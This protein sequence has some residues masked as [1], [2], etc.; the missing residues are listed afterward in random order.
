MS[1]TASSNV[2]HAEPSASQSLSGLPWLFSP[3]VDICTF[4]GSALAAFALLAVGWYRGWLTSDSPEWS[5]VIGVLLIDVAHVYST[6]FRVYFDREE[7]RHRP[8]LYGLTPLLAFLI[9]WALHSESIELFWRTLAY[10]AVFHFIRQQYG[11]VALYR[12]RGSEHDRW[13]WWID[14]TAIYL[15]TIYPLVH[16]HGEL[17]RQ[18]WWLRQGDFAAIP[19][20]VSDLLMPIYWAAMAV[21]AGRSLYRGMVHGRWNPG[22]DMVVATTALCWYVGIITF[23]SD[24]AFLVTNVIIH[25]VPYMVLVYRFRYVGQRAPQQRVR[26]PYWLRFLGVVWLLAY[27]EELLWD[28][29]IWHE[30][31]WL[32]GG[33]V[34]VAAAETW[35]V[36]LLAVPQL[37]HYVLDGFIWRRRSNQSVSQ[38]FGSQ[39]AG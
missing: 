33:G 16:W 10:L 37:T 24:Y 20:M 5:W 26:V 23:N 12:A 14:A 27:I 9:G 3:W 29:T 30:R 11:W 19:A 28:T 15:A 21:Y 38:T 31:A 2:G 36:P 17:P 39:P 35:I 22:K 18:F 1:S 13:G 32:F 4:L 7:L 8:A 25:G 34:D 6:G